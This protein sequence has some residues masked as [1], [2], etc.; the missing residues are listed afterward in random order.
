MVPDVFLANK[1]D[2]HA[3]ARFLTLHKLVQVAHDA[4]MSHRENVVRW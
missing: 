2:L 1:H 4:R 3:E